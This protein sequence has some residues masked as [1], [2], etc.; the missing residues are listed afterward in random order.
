MACTGKRTLIKEFYD[1]EKLTRF[2][3]ALE[4][5]MWITPTLHIDRDWSVGREH[6]RPPTKRYTGANKTTTAAHTVEVCNPQ[7]RKKRH[8]ERG[9][10]IVKQGERKTQAAS[11]QYDRL[12]K[13]GLCRVGD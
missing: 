1:L 9:R 4:R 5:L 10:A 12:T 3:L 6:L 11:V 2:L 8:I 13:S 7:Y